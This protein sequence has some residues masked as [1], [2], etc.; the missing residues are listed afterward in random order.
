MSWIQIKFQTLPNQAELL[1]DLLL[2]AGSVAVTFEKGA[3][4]EL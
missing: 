4:S 2:A 3:F 1:E